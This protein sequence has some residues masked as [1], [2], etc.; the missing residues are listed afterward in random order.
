MRCHAKGH[1]IAIMQCTCIMPLW[2]KIALY[3]LDLSLGINTFS[4]LVSVTYSILYWR[5][6]NFLN[7]LLTYK[8]FK[9]LKNSIFLSARGLALF[10][11]HLLSDLLAECSGAEFPWDRIRPLFRW[12]QTPERSDRAHCDICTVHALS[13]IFED[14]TL[15]F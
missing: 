9:K 7:V 4:H 11:F 3:S 10:L 13:N 6:K 14:K 5:K 15:H 12:K 8:S 1:I 2:A